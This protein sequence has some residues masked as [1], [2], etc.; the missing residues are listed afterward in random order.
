MI[1]LRG[2]VQFS[3]HTCLS[4][5]ESKSNE[6]IFFPATVQCKC[7]GWGYWSCVC[8]ATFLWRKLDGCK[9]SRF[10]QHNMPQLL[11]QLTQQQRED[12][13][14]Q[15]DGAPPHFTKDVRQWWPKNYPICIGRG[16][17]VAWPPMSPD[18][19]PLEFYVWGYMKSEVYKTVV[20]DENDLRNRIVEAAN[21]V[22]NK[23]SFQVNVRAVR[24]RARAFVRENGGQFIT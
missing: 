9:I 17:T 5:R 6:G 16:G 18:L 24:K 23:L 14:F 10:L 13:I 22:K 19:T 15:Q 3:Q 8:G 4:N 2:S 7:V 12:L 20:G 1:R 11:D 21:K